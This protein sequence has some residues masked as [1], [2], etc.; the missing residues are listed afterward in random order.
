MILR[1]QVPDEVYEA[2]GQVNP[3]NPRKV[4]EALLEKFSGANPAGKQILIEGEELSRLQGLLSTSVDSAESLLEAIRVALLF[5]VDDVE[6]EL[7]DAQRKKLVT[8]A[9]AWKREP[10][11]FI[12]QQVRENLRSL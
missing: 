3:K 7:T 8:Q 6:V 5:K 4:M 1:M 11:E 9:S 12:A 2:F 10:A